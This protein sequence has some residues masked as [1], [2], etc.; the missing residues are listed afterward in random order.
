[1]LDLAKSLLETSFLH[2]HLGMVGHCLQASFFHTINSGH[3][4]IIELPLVFLR[5]QAS[6]FHHNLPLVGAYCCFW[7]FLRLIPSFFHV[8]FGHERLIFL[9][10]QFGHGRLNLLSLHSGHG[11][12]NLVPLVSFR[13]LRGAF[14]P[15][16]VFLPDYVV[17]LRP[18]RTWKPH[19]AASGVFSSFFWSIWR[20][21]VVFSHPFR[22]WDPHFAA[23]GVFSS[24]FHTHFGNGSLIL[25]HLAFSRRFFTPISDMGSSLNCLCCFFASLCRFCSLLAVI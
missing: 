18:F 11:R 3:C 20:F 13:L 4:R 24:F 22:K 1:M 14:S 21:F 2:I 6:F 9:P 19:F 12:L 8:L 15:S 16:G 10:I 7:R 5:L 23:S 25:L 17:F